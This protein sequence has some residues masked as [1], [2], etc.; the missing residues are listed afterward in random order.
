M[1]RFHAI[2][3]WTLIPVNVDSSNLNLHLQILLLILTPLLAWFIPTFRLMPFVSILAIVWIQIRLQLRTVSYVSYLVPQ[4]PAQRIIPFSLTGHTCHTV[5]SAN[6]LT[7]KISSGTTF[8][9]EYH[10][11]LYG[12]VKYSNCLY[13]VDI[14]EVYREIKSPYNILVTPIRYKL[15]S[16]LLFQTA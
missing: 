2:W 7:T 5:W 12:V 10:N 11:D 13:F 4:L 3:S 15:F 1:S 16:I 9:K 6:R 14:V 8:Y